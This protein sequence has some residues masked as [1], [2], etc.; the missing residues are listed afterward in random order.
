MVENW[1]WRG[2]TGVWE[3]FGSHV[4]TMADMPPPGPSQYKHWHAH[5]IECQPQQRSDLTWKKDK[6][7]HQ[8]AQDTCKTGKLAN[9][10]TGKLADWAMRCVAGALKF[11]FAEMREVHTHNNMY[12]YIQC[13][14][15]RHRVALSP[16]VVTVV[17][18]Q[19]VR[20]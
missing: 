4:Q 15:P 19:T 3:R 11:N 18:S 1:K 5:T 2:G 13:K 10:R 16:I 9:R 12:I 14:S 17:G 20:C 7:Q 6:G 8:P